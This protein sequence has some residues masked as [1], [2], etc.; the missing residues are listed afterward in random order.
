MNL[1]FVATSLLAFCEHERRQLRG[2]S[3]LA[4]QSND[5]CGGGSGGG[6]GGSAHSHRPSTSTVSSTVPSSYKLEDGRILWSMNCEGRH[7]IRV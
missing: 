1:I 4:Y 6:G 2:V 3:S 5:G 7:R